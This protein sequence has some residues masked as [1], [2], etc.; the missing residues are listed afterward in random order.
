MNNP[1]PKQFLKIGDDQLLDHAIEAFLGW[2]DEIIVTLPDLAHAGDLRHRDRVRFVQGGATRTDSVRAGLAEVHD[3]IVLVHDA[4]R[5]FV[6]RELLDSLVGALGT[7]AC[8]CPVMPVVNSIV[9]DEDGQL[10]ETPD[11]ARYR[12]V[13]TPQ[14]FRTQVLREAIERFGDA[15]AHL[16]ELVRRAGYPVKHVDGSPWLFKVTYEPSLYMANYYVEHVLPK[17]AGS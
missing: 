15:H 17:I 6:T 4:A 5:P 12:E 13:Q 1:V 2:A 16:P 9:V 10:A 7:F 11:R 3:D 8:A 14:A